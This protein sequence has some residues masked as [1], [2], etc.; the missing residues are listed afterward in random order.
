MTVLRDDVDEVFDNAGNL[1]SS[2][3]VQRDI[4]H[5]ANLREL[6]GKARTALTVNDNYLTIADTASNAQVRTQVERL[7]RECS[8][9]IRELGAVIDDMRDLLD[10]TDGT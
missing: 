9:I 10:T 3:P 2:T 1:I 6:I 7:T 4:T 8:G 5:E